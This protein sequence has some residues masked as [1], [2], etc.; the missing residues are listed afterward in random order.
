MDLTIK[1]DFSANEVP[2][3]LTPDCSANA[4]LYKLMT[5]GKKLTA[6]PLYRW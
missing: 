3:Y 2:G 6:I 1:F 4:D 5:A